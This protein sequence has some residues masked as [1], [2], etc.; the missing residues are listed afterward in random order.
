[1]IALRKVKWLALAALLSLLAAL[2]FMLD[3]FYINLATQ[4]LYLGLFALSINL[5]GG[6]GGMVTLGQ[7]GISG[8]AAYALGI[9]VTRADVPLGIGLVLGLVVAVVAAFV[10]GVLA[11]RAS[12]VYFLMITLAEGMIV[13]GIAQRWTTV[14]G[15]DNGLTGIDRP[16]F[17]AEYWTYY[18]L[19]LGV[20]LVCTLLIFTIVRSPFGLSLKGIRESEGRM[21]PL[22]YNVA[23]HKLLAFTISGTFAG[24]SGLLLAMYNSFFSPASVHVKAS[25]DGLLMSILGGMGTLP[26]AFVGSTIYV[27]VTNYVSGFLDRWPTL[28]GGIFVLTILFAQDGIVGAWSRRV[29]APLVRRTEGDAATRERISGPVPGAREA[30]APPRSA[31]AT[32]KTSSDRP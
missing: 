1:M 21:G 16:P 6:Y 15:G 19:T 18:Y 27:F 2:P 9:A 14:T 7:A 31:T 23:L 24:I 32:E 26:G 12:G 20:V 30:A 22:G 5:I 28:L 13:W 29:W 10:F 11:V 3:S 17:A 8:M 25:A 4:A